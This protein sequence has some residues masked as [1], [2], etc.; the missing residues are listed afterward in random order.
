MLDFDYP[1]HYAGLIQQVSWDI[2]LPEQWNE[3]FTETGVVAVV[4]PDRRDKQRR[5]VR[6]RGLMSIDRPLPSIKREKR[7]F[8]VYTKDFSKDACGVVTPFQLYPKERVRLVLPT[9]WLELRVV[10]CHRETS[11]CFDTGFALV[12]R[13]DPDRSAFISGG[14]FLKV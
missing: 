11:T 3:F 14:N 13:H 5:I 6:M 8:G 2:E 4:D 12:R 9:F 7:F 1:V 10:R